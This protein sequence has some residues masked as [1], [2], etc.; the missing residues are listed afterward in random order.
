MVHKIWESY[1]TIEKALYDVKKLMKNSIKVPMVEVNNKILEYIDAPGKYL[2]SGLTIMVA[3]NLGLP[4]D[5][6]VISAAAGLE[7]MHLSTL[8]HDDVI[9]NADTRRGVTVIHKDFSNKIAIYAGDYLLSLSGRLI[10]ESNLKINRNMIDNKVIEHILIGELRQLMNQN[11]DDMT[12]NDYLRQIKGKTATLFG[13]AV[14]IG[15]IKAE[16]PRRDLKRLYYAGQMIGMAFQLNDDLIDYHQDSAISGKPKL[17]DVQNGI[18]TAPYLML[19]EQ[20]DNIKDLEYDELPRLMK[21]YQIFDSVEAVITSYLNKSW[22]YFELVNI[23]PTKIKEL[24][25]KLD[26]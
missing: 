8:I 22:H 14:L 24:L 26:Y 13:L 16:L 17:Q 10:V 19:K 25:Q 4:I 15:G 3:D 6:D 2:R 23:N 1:P 5:H 11:R 21:E 9:D 18:Y 12:M 20:V 7:L